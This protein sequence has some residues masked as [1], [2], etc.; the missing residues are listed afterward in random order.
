MELESV[1]GGSYT[2]CG[3]WSHYYMTWLDCSCSNGNSHN[4]FT[5]IANDC[6]QG[7]FLHFSFSRVECWFLIIS[8]SPQRLLST[9]S[10]CFHQIDSA[11]IW[12]M[13]FGTLTLRK[14]GKR[15]KMPLLAGTSPA[16]TPTGK[17]KPLDPEVWKFELSWLSRQGPHRPSL[18]IHVWGLKW[19]NSGKIGS[20]PATGLQKN[21]VWISSISSIWLEVNMSFWCSF[22]NHIS[23]LQDRRTP[24]NRT[25]GLWEA[26]WKHESNVV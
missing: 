10:E 8:W 2:C 22:V 11:R 12:S 16:Q 7:E 3:I 18:G 23:N 6:V 24:W 13:P 9:M 25:W 17:P 21:S 19:L 1:P 15:W 5:F 26:R 20:S 4:W 14:T